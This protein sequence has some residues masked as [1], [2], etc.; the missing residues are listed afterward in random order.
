MVEGSLGEVEGP[1]PHS[2]QGTVFHS[3]KRPE[4]VVVRFSLT[5]CQYL[6]LDDTREIEV[7]TKRKGC[8]MCR[9]HLTEVGL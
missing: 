4:D 9:L 6:R 8:Q 3:R 2:R 1:G 7:Q 5:L